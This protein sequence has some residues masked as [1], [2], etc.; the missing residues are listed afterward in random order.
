MWPIKREA[1]LEAK[2]HTEGVGTIVTNLQALET[3]LRYFLLRLHGEEVSFP[4]VGDR[5]AKITQLTRWV[6]LG[7]LIKEYN[8]ALK[9]EEKKYCVDTTVVRIR[10]AFA[11]GRLL[12]SK[13][14]PARLWKFGA[15][16][17]G[18]VLNRIL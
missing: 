17:K 9:Q 15:E 14:I 7:P 3:V 10:D 4:K 2:E 6:S 12:T 1:H 5:K 16:K 13:E 8:S 11:H 18:Q